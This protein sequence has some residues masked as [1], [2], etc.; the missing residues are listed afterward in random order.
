MA[1]TAVTLVV[2]VVLVVQLPVVVVV[3]AVPPMELIQEPV[4]QVVQ[5]CVEST[6]G[7]VIT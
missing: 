2:L 1:E 5:G 7:K 3:A 4:E 6:L